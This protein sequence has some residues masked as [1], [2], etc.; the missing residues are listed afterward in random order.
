MPSDVFPLPGLTPLTQLNVQDS[1][2]INAERWDLAHQYHRQRQNIHYQALWQ[3]GIVYGLGVKLITPPAGTTANFRSKS[4]IEVQPG[5]AIDGEGNPILVGPEQDRT[6][7][8]AIPPATGHIQTLYVVLRHVDPRQLEIPNS[9]DRL[10]EQFRFDQRVNQLEPRDIELCRVR[11]SPAQ[12]SLAMPTLDGQPEPGQLDLHYRRFAQLRSQRS[13]TL[14]LLS[15]HAYYAGV[16]NR[17][18]QAMQVL[19]SDL[20]GQLQMLA[21]EKAGGLDPDGGMRFDALWIEGHRLIT[22]QQSDE[23]RHSQLLQSIRA[24]T[25]TLIIVADSLDQSLQT[26]LKR[27]RRNVNLT[28]VAPPHPIAQFPFLFGRLPEFSANEGLWIDE[29]IIVIPS[30]IFQYWEGKEQS[31]QDVRTWHEFG[32]N[33]LYYIW[34]NSHI[35]KLLQ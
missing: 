19:Y 17:L 3:P 15:P 21:A 18:F 12:T 11:L 5:F 13:F 27:L 33:L 6:Y 22:W 8:I 10:P 23:P 31:R 2:R 30:E 1:L 14:G 4:W 29:R 16:L 20:H 24:Y 34:Y 7:P 28:P 9:T 35:H 25:G 26:A 32:I